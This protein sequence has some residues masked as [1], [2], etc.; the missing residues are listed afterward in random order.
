MSSNAY[1]MITADKMR[2]LLSENEYKTVLKAI[3]QKLKSIF[4]QKSTISLAI[5]PTIMP[6]EKW[7]AVEN[8]ALFKVCKR[9][10]RKCGSAMAINDGCTCWQKF[11]SKEKNPYDT[12]YLPESIKKMLAENFGIKSF[13]ALTES[14]KQQVEIEN[15]QIEKQKLL[16]KAQK[17]HVNGPDFWISESGETMYS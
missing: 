16:A 2:F 15:A 10:C 12:K 9:L 17:D 6:Y 7:Y 14:D 5:T 1:V 4:L 3:S 11:G 13:P 8:E